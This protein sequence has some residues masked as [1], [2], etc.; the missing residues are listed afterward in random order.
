MIYKGWIGDGEIL[1]L[2]LIVSYIHIDKSQVRFEDVTARTSVHGIQMTDGKAKYT[3]KLTDHTK[4]L[5]ESG[6]R[7]VEN[8]VEKNKDFLKKLAKY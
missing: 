2:S 4:G 7:R 5:S 8:I 3:V 1:K 6:R